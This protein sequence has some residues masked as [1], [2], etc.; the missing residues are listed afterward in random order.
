MS[1]N[2]IKN[3]EEFLFKYC[4][5]NGLFVIFLPRH[6]LTIMAKKSQS[7]QQQLAKNIV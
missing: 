2:Q 5:K 3:R 4:N 6:T 7:N 1:L